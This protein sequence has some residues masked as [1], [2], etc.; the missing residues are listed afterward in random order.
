MIALG[1]AIR[2]RR[3]QLAVSQKSLGDLAGC[4][5]LFIHQLERGK[6]TVRLD[7]LLSVLKVLN[8]QLTLTEGNAGIEV[9]K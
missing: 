8:L 3:K 5:A 4:G 6:P 9:P 1:A 2:K 7:K